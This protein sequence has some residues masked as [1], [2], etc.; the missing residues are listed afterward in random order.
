MV[1][2][3]A[4]SGPGSETFVASNGLGEDARRH[5]AQSLDEPASPGRRRNAE[6]A[7]ANSHHEALA[8]ARKLF[9]TFQSAPNPRRR[10]QDVLSELSRAE[11]WGPRARRE[12]AEAETWLQSL[13][14]ELELRSRLKALLAKLEG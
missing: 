9:R 10:A 2:G 3:K 11:G 8:Q 1:V 4:K 13:P 7:M 5:S 12:I 14:S 6:F